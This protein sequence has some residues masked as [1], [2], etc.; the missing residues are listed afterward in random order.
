[1]LA[2][3]ECRHP[4]PVTTPRNARAFP[5]WLAIALCITGLVAMLALAWWAYHPGLPG[6]FL[7]DDFAN[8]PALGATG[9]VD[10]WA[11]F[12]RYIT[13]GDADPT[14][15]PLTLLTFLIDARNWPASP[16]PFKV[17]NVILHLVNGVLLAW[18]LWWLG[19]MLSPS[20]SGRRR[21]QA[22]RAALPAGAGEDPDASYAEHRAS[23]VPSPG[24]TRHPLPEGEGS[25]GAAALD[26]QGIALA[27]LFGAGAWLLHPL[28]VSATLYIV[29][30]EAMLPATFMLTGMLGW[31]ASRDALAR[32]HLKRALVG[33]ALSAWLCTALAVLSKANGALLPLLLLLVEWIVLA[34][35][36]LPDATAQ[37]RHRRAVTVFLIVPS[38]LVIAYLLYLLPG[39]IHDA[40]A[41]RGW[42]V[43]QRL[44]TEPRVMTDYLRLL[45]IPHAYSS[46][47]F[48]DSFPASTG[49]LHPASTIFC[50]VLILALIGAG[51]ALRKKHPAI[52]LALLFY[53]TAQLM[54]SG[55]IPLE[56]YYEHRNYLPSMLLFWPIGIGLTRPGLLRGARIACATGLLL[57]L[58]VLTWQRANLWG[59]GFRQA[60]IWAAIN[61]ESPRAQTNAALYD[62]AHDRPRLAAARLQLALTRHPGS[63]QIPVNLVTAECRL[64][65]VDP[66]I[67]AAARRAMA[68]TGGGGTVSFHWFNQTLE[69]VRASNC[70]GLDFAMLQSMLDAARSNPHWRKR[71]GLQQDLDHLQGEL[72]LAAGKPA[73]AL[74]A[75]DRA[76]A[77]WPRPEVALQQ[78]AYLGSHGFPREG[79]QHLDYSTTLP[80]GPRPGFG[81]P[82][83]HAWVLREQ[84]WWRNETARLRTTLESDAAVKHD[85]GV[86]N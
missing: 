44:L 54:E 13:S 9:P 23:V 59:D 53:F 49:W 17:T 36:P 75:F 79:L 77:V 1:M 60:Q 37:H 78:A 70:R 29:Q 40:S 47:L 41:V 46:G 31:M 21:P 50:V 3:H 43:G 48:N 68:D 57:A 39:A 14:G 27:A 28:F 20:P 34:R 86:S 56:L 85:E 62:L 35:R 72:D 76:L 52:A 42:T 26:N 22:E 73:Q 55:W 7:F 67:L 4:D 80:P 25:S 30:R 82:R 33:M 6:D 24:A 69:M 8:L 51:F 2:R 83:I 5:R 32:G 64:G 12:W 19:K 84:G 45:F 66:D 71:P 11:T 18:V 65:S 81:M 38:A 10:T 58:A 74:A 61:P 16:Y 15:R 63:V